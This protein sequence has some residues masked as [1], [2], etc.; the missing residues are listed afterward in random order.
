MQTAPIILFVYN[1]PWHTEQTLNALMKNELADQSI[2]YI[3][4]DGPKGNDDGIT[5]YNLKKTR[6]L[7]KSKKWCKEVF[8]LEREYNFGLANSIIYGV[9]SIVNKYGKVIVLEDDIVTSKGFLT[10][11]NNSLSLYANESNVGCIHGWNY[12]L[13]T[14]GYNESTFFLR[15]ADCW[16]WATWKRAWILFNSDGS[17]LLNTIL[18]QQLE[19]K[20]NRNGTHD[21]VSMLKDQIH[22]KNDSWAI[23][24]HAS[25]FLA[26]KYCLQPTKPIVKN[27][28]LDNSGIHCGN[29]DLLQNCID[30]IEV[31][32]IKIQEPEWFYVAYDSS[33]KSKINIKKNNMLV[34]IKNIIKEFI[35]P[36]IIRVLKKHNRKNVDQAIWS[37]DFASWNE[38]KKKC[39]GYDT[40][41]ILDK[42]KNALL[43]VKNGEALYERDSVIFDEIEYSWGLLAGLQKTALENNG[44]LCVLDFGG[45]LGSTYYQNKLF[46][47]SFKSIEWCIVEQLHFVDCGRENFENDELKFYYN[48]EECLSKHNP[49]VLIFSG[50]LQYLENPYEFLE[51]LIQ[52]K[53][54]NII[55]DR[56]AFIN[57]SKG[58]LT[59]QVV[60]PE[61]YE[62]SYPC[63]FFNELDFV[64]KFSCNYNLITSFES[65]SDSQRNTENGN[66][67]YWKGF[68]FQ[69]K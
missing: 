63:W 32:K 50:V 68:Y 9:T 15:G 60:P 10:Y 41:L 49:N 6:E 67:L 38:A 21:F 66:L 39:T 23:L 2:L 33:F 34:E 57:T 54:P 64:N 55:I 31:S 46:L 37:G 42:C 20:F 56:T 36:I 12:T 3:Y 59:V 7:I 35:P 52:L 65:Y 16:G 22:D 8:I 11:M 58:L 18:S 19:Y 25:L 40:M 53:I 26:N 62:A 27:I 45:S 29:S 61:I 51:K 44:N 28:G 14:I 5:L 1:R 13:N 47:N 17:Y 69:Q 43:K 4:A 24:W 48:T 30:Y